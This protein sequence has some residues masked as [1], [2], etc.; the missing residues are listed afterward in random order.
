MFNHESLRYNAAVCFLCGRP[1]RVGSPVHE[2]EKIGL[3]HERC[4]RDLV[5]KMAKAVDV[6]ARFDHDL[7][8]NG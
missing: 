1:I 3:C 2:E 6:A 8:L 4:K 7:V 5:D